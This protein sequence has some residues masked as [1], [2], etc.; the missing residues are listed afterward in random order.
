MINMLDTTA[1]IAHMGGLI[2]GIVLFYFFFSQDK[3]GLSVLMGVMLLCLFYKYATIKTISPLYPGT[4]MEVVQI[5]NDLGMRQYAA[6]LFR[7]LT[8]LYTQYGGV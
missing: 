6:N 5:Y 3:I 4:D 8:Q 1:Y 2:A 7:R